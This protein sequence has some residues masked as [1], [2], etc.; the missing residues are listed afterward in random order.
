MTELGHLAVTMPRPNKFEQASSRTDHLDGELDSNPFS[1]RFIRPDCLAYH[2]VPEWEPGVVWAKLRDANFVG[3][4][5]GPHGAGKTAL[6]HQLTDRFSSAGIR[7]QWHTVRAGDRFSPSR[8]SMSELTCLEG[9]ELLSRWNLWRILRRAR[10]G[11]R[12]IL[13]THRV[14]RS[15][16]VIA[17]LEPRLETAQSIAKN[18][19]AGRDCLIDADEVERCYKKHRGNLREMLLELYDVYDA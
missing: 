8:L 15:I 2:T 7:W 6:L 19:L 4:I 12:I 18:L 9:A 13:T 14:L 5:V 10:R 11:Y 1:T 16:A 17:N 3:Q